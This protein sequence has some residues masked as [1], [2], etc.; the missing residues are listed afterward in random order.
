MEKRIVWF[1]VISLFCSTVI[2]FGVIAEVNSNEKK[3]K[4]IEKTTFE[5]NVGVIGE[6]PSIEIISPES[7]Y[8]YLF[9]LRPIKMPIS[10][11]LELGHS[12]V[13]G[14]S[15]VIDTDSENIHHVKFVARGKFTGWETTRWD[16]KNLDGLSM[17]MGLPSGIYDITVHA[18]DE[19]D[20]EVGSDS[21]KVFFIK[22]GSD[23]FGIMINTKYD[24]GET[25]TKP[26]DIGITEFGSMLST[27]DPKTFD[28]TMQNED[29][30]TVEL[31]FVRTS[32]ISGSE[33]VI[34][35]KFNVETDCDTTKD[36]DVSL[37]FKFPFT[38]LGGG[39]PSDSNNPYFKASV[40]Y[41]SYSEE[42]AGA[43]K[44]DT[45]F[46]FGRERMDDPRVFRLKLNP[47]SIGSNTKNSF[48]S[49]YEAVDGSGDEVFQRVF[50]TDFEPATELTIT[51]IPSEAKIQYDFGES[52]GV[53][54]KITFDAQGGLFD[55]I[56]QSYEIDPL[57]SYMAFDLTIIGAREFIYESDS[58]YDVTY[59]LD[60]KQDG[61]LVRFEVNQ[62][63]ETIHASWGID[64]GTFGD[65]SA[66]SF[67]ELDMSSDVQRLALYL[68]DNEIPFVNIE[69]FPRNF[70]LESFVDIPDGTGNITILRGID[71]VR[72]IS[73]ALAFDEIVVTKSF[74]LKNNFVQLAWDID[75]IDGHGI[76][77]VNRD[78]DSE[79]ILS[80]SIEYNEWI[81]TKSLELRNSHVALEWDID[82]EERTGN[83]AF[84]R[85]SEGGDPSITFSIA[86]DGWEIADTI[87]LKNDLIELYWDLP[88]ADDPHAEIGINKGGG[89]Q[90][91]FY[92]TI[93]IIDDSVELLSFGIGLETEND[94]R[95]SW[96]NDGG[97]IS[98]FEWSGKIR[99]LSNLDVSVNLP[100]DILTISGSWTVSEAGQ[101]NLAL[102]QPVDI[103]FV[104]F[105][106]NRFKIQGHIS[107][108]ADRQL[109]V[110]WNLSDEG[111]FTVNTNGEPLGEEAS[112][113]ALFDPQ[114]QANYKYGFSLTAPDFLETAATVSWD[115]DYVIP[116]ILVS[117]QLPSNWAQWEKLLLWDYDWY[118]IG[119]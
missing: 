6:D 18:Y 105:E 9:K 99:K 89:D 119:L 34:E 107:F 49:S 81:F 32:I 60:S 59:S 7:G 38:L 91:L 109:D 12:V 108:Y 82:R 20:V 14:Q 19:G 80:T 110:A 112:F 26:L 103:T 100:G 66:S 116:R 5:N 13:I 40:G 51:T 45:T 70:R 118:E 1:V 114:N 86:H 21:I 35:T 85:D 25:I 93:S 22:I 11:A 39:Q 90:E 43:N 30:T 46:Y 58:T 101:L 33:N 61:N 48:Y 4:V 67:A 73:V 23:D 74:G 72:E 37:E 55:D 92:N 68:N 8:L 65:L 31:R 111:F 50:T 41:T 54:T 62:V 84:S 115:R 77:E 42:G 102:N 28:V 104:D 97:V 64:L 15:L 96:D 95:L 52:A 117:G 29:D 88:T 87:D 113:M 106:T 56:Y 44:V 47:N 94:F 57:P 63:P 79:M 71:E 76:I 16:Y 10:S 27:G 36:Y 53:P 17:N 83:I 24:D 69:D 2:S 3:D 98:N 78:A 75:L